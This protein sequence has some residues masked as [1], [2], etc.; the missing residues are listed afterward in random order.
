MES[1]E[2]S[3]ERLKRTLYS[4]DE[5]VVPKERRTPVEP[6]P[7]NVPTD[8]GTPKSFDI[9]PEIMVK[10]N[11][12][13]FNKFLLGSVVFFLASV[14]VALFIFYGGFN[15]I[16]SNNLDIKIVAPSSVSSGEELSVGLTVA[17]SNRTDLENVNLVI[18][19]PIGTQSIEEGN[20]VL[21]RERI[22]LGTIAKG[23]TS[24]HSIRVLIFGEKDAVK[25]FKF[26]LD[27]RVKGSNATF[28]KEKTYDVLI[29]SS[30]ILLNVLYP[31]EVN[32]GQ[33]INL[34]VDVTSNSTV[35]LKDTLVKVEYPYGFTY[36]D[37]NIKPIRDNSIWN[38]GDLKGGDKKTLKIKGVLVGQ[39]LEDRSFRV[40]AGIQNGDNSK[41]FDTPLASSAVTVGIRKS[42]FDL[43]LDVGDGVVD[44]GQQIPVNIKWQNTLPDKVL[45]S[46]IEATL[47]GNILD[48]SSVQVGDGG[49]YRS[50]DDTVLWSKN[51]TSILGSILAGED[52]DV[53]FSMSSINNQVAVRSI[54]NPHI[55]VHVVMTGD[56]SGSDSGT[57]SSSADVTIKLSSQLA[58]S[59]KSYRNQGSLTN[60]G[61][62]PPRADKETTYTVT[63][64][65]TNT[66]ND[67][68]DTVVSATL[69]AGVSW[70][71]EV[72]PASD[73]INYNPDTRVVSWNAGNITAGTGYSLSPKTISFKLGLTPS[74]SQ[75]NSIGTLLLQTSVNSTDT[76]TTKSISLNAP[77]VTTQF[78]D[79]S[80]RQGDDIIG[81]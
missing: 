56:R 68:K 28:S 22:P 39:N 71:S 54:K 55:D 50:V 13:F 41:D 2:S 69:P 47:S 74:V 20:K 37:S 31:S 58:I 1:D 25:Q 80:F 3:I 65:L 60:S 57:I 42:F 35:V 48:R 17:N 66:T 34:S 51:S 33:E 18:E 7:I 53:S 16:S 6:H 77:Q 75:I 36:K 27:Y 78:S 8:W 49:F 12:S 9:S 62:I 4:R 59:A 11:N 21:T 29:G 73:K 81:R 63:W 46:H 43:A 32:S 76:Y 40:S 19:Y 30:P 10:H 14:G 52:G 70:K 23:G 5:A 45:N 64:S 38:I 44:V 61:P 67:L 72:S 15:M 24:D 79:S 26:S